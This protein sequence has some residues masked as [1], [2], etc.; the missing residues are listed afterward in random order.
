[1]LTDKLFSR[2]VL[3]FV[4]LVGIAEGRA[5]TSN[6]D[7]FMVRSALIMNGREPILRESKCDRRRRCSLVAIPDQIEI[8]LRR[9]VHG[10]GL[11]E[12]SIRCHGRECSFVSGR[13]IVQFSNS[14]G[15]SE[16]VITD[17]APISGIET[18]LVQ[19]SLSEIGRIVVRY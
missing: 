4:C 10:G 8:E 14:L 12:I 13:K 7:E 17:G 15:T 6:A 5:Q 19:K 11:D 18:P 2:A 3:T 9:E 16:F 1:M